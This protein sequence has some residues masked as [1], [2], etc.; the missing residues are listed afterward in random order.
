MSDL[1]SKKYKHL[2]TE[3]RQEIMECLEKGL[4]FKDIARRIRKDPTTISKEVKKH[5]TIV[6]TNVKL[7]KSDGTPINE[8]RCP[9]LLKAPFVCNP[10]EKRR[11]HC[12]FQKQLYIAKS[13]HAD[14][15]TLLHEAREGIPLS[16]DEFWEADA[17]I[18]EGIQ[19]GQRLYHIMATHDVGF[20]KSSAYR[21]LHRGYLSASKLDFPRVVKFKARKQYKADSVPKAVK[22]GRTYDDFLLFIKEHDI[23]TWVEMDTVIGRQGGK[24]IMTF[25]FTYCNFMFGLLLDDKTAAEAALKIRTLKEIFDKSGIRFGDVIQL[26][27]TDNGGEFANVSAFT[28]DMDGVAETNLFFCDPYCSSQKPKVEKN[29][30]LFRDIVPKGESFDCFTQEAVNLIFSHV[31]SIKRKRF[32][33][34][35]PYEMFSFVYGDT[36]L[37]LLGINE[38]P[39]SE[40]IQSPRLLKMIKETLLA[41]KPLT[42]PGLS[43]HGKE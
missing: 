2:T 1:K 23:N 43:S 38:I 17:I 41:G 33:G 8:R 10:C 12:Q 25:D 19:K 16:K 14:Y 28:D 34:K 15:K 29:H 9:L 7:S 21:H 18:K 6:E 13:A 4:T 32:N 39:A 35:A 27:L 22:A 30:T 20:S 3:D 37:A 11:R 42:D 40:V 36:I 26:L 24:V 31:N 5:L